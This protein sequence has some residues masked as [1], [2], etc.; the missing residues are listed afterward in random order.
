METVLT[1]TFK[2]VGKTGAVLNAD[3]FACVDA[4]GELV[5]G[6]VATGLAVLGTL[7]ESVTGDGVTKQTIKLGGKVLA[8]N[9]VTAAVAV[10]HIGDPVY[11]FNG[12]TVSSN[13]TGTSVAGICLG[14]VGTKVLVRI[15]G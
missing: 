13:S 6:A 15:A 2:Y 7:V 14:F 1:P 9:D 4:T 3:E 11:V 8:N 5:A 12:S 10:A